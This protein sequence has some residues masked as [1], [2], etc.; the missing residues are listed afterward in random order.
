MR[1]KFDIS[2]TKLLGDIADLP[3]QPHP[4]LEVSFRIL[5]IRVSSIPDEVILNRLGNIIWND[6]FR[7][8]SSVG[9]TGDVYSTL[10]RGGVQR[11]MC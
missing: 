10:F 5:C 9:T 4:S 2:P 1:L 8:L 7:G 6:K 3:G 11:G